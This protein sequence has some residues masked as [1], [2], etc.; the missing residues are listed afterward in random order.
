MNFSLLGVVLILI[1]G[2]IIIITGLCVDT[3]TG[4][5]RE[6]YGRKV[7]KAQ[8]WSAEETLALQRAAYEG[9]GLWGFGK[10]VPSSL[11]FVDR[12]SS[13]VTAV[14]TSQNDGKANAPVSVQEI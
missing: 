5:A 6:K 14:R 9:L 2:G 8:Q 7:W 11:V 10:E 1:I 4:W 13:L 12:R 3:A